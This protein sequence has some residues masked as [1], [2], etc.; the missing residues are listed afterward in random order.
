MVARGARLAAAL[1]ALAAALG[2]APRAPAP[3]APDPLAL[4]KAYRV[5]A[6]GE[7]TVN[8]LRVGGRL[9][10]DYL[11][12]PDDRVVVSD[13]T[14][15]VRDVDIVSRFA[16]I[17]TGR[18]RLRCTKLSNT[19][20]LP[21]RLEP[22]GRLVLPTDAVD[23]TGVSF[24]ER[25]ADGRCTG[26]ARQVTA[27]NNADVVARHDPASDRFELSGT[28]HGRH[29]GDDL[30]IGI[31]MTGRYL[32]RPPVAEIGVFEPLG[33]P[34]TTTVW[35]EDLAWPQGGCPALRGTNPPGAVANGPD[36]LRLNLISLSSD[37]DG[38]VGGGRG[39]LARDVWSLSSDGGPFRALGTRQM[40][41]PVLFEL[42]RDHVLSLTSSD[43]AGAQGRALCRFRV[44]TAAEAGT[45][46]G[47]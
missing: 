9:R 26:L 42:H 10:M 20:G 33:V 14:A 1:A 16:F 44:I 21:G 6:D 36:G 23:L 34:T 43:H 41:G 40:V 37:P 32:N 39:D 17:E 24:A 18:E 7:L 30:A 11:V 8:D 12:F 38:R 4:P 28:F 27:R 29:G 46:G 47:S 45:G 5:Q 22:G 15:W 13:L 35:P 2:C 25:G 31:A 19:T 3:A